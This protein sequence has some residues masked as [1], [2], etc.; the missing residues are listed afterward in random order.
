MALHRLVEHFVVADGR[1][2][3]RVPIDQPLA[4]IDFAFLEEVE[5]RFAHRPRADLVERESGPLP[6]ATTAHLLQLADDAG[7]VVVLPLPDAFDE[8]FAAQ[9]VPAELLL[10]EQPPLDDRLRGDAGMIGARHPKGLEP[11]HPFL[12]DEDVL[13]RVVQGVAKVQGPGHVGRRD[14][15]GIRLAERVRLAMEKAL[16][17]PERIPACLGRR[18]I[19]L[20]RKFV[21]GGVGGHVERS[22]QWLVVSV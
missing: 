2:Q 8:P 11:L 17:L 6:V 4:A 13:E 14:D 10:A 19:V 9:F 16:L 7:F 3:E 12:A 21:D 22:R 1:L 18:V 5:K 15:D 20:F